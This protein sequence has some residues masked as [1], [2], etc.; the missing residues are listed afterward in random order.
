MVLCR[1]GLLLWCFL[2]QCSAQCGLGQQMRT[3]QCLSYTG[4]PSNDCAESLRPATM[5]QCESKC[6]A[7][8]VSS[9]DGR[10]MKCAIAFNL[11]CVKVFIQVEKKTAA[12]Q[13]LQIL[14][15][16]ALCT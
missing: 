13:L 2:F 5:Q 12:L 16:M 1:Q 10:L 6:D 11:C 9:G 8:P 7:T 4:Q 3:V 15:L 14:K